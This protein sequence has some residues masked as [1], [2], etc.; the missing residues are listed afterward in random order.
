MR[1]LIA[2]ALT[3]MLLTGCGFGP[4]AS[5]ARRNGSTQLSHRAS[6]CRQHQRLDPLWV[7]DQPEEKKALEAAWSTRLRLRALSCSRD[8]A[9]SWRDSA[10]DVRARRRT[11]TAG[12]D[13]EL[14]A[15]GRAAARETDAR[16]GPSAAAAPGTAK[17]ISRTDY[18]STLVTAQ[19][20]GG[21]AV[22]RADS[23]LSTSAPARISSRS[24]R[25]PGHSRPMALSPNGRLVLDG[26][27]RQRWSYV[28]P[29]GRDLVELLRADDMYWL[30]ADNVVALRNSSGCGCW[31]CPAGTKTRFR[32]PAAVTR[33]WLRPCPASPAYSFF[34]HRGV[35]QVEISDLRPRRSATGRRKAHRVRLGFRGQHWRHVR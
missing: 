18:V 32:S 4:S 1:R 10:A 31:I 14:L 21:A 22:A 6:A 35:D 33:T 15:L 9:P 30:D 12:A 20:T 24:R 28:P 16:P 7:A 29:R 11:P 34:V 5:A 25:P 8:F 23:R 13:R 3:T 17:T 19:R 26:D 2:S 27:V